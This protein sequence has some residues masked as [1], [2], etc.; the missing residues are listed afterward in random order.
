MNMLKKRSQNTYFDDLSEIKL[1]KADPQWKNM[2]N[3]STVL[4]S[5]RST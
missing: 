1:E 4:N 3:S 2:M 5:G